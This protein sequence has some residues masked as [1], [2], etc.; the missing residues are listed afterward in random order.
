MQL[1]KHI[2]HTAKVPFKLVCVLLALS[3]FNS[4]LHGNAA[5]PSDD[6]I[7][8]WTLSHL[9][10]RLTEIDSELPQLSQLSLRGGVG[11]IGYR[12]AWWQAAVG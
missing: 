10:E 1:K 4:L 6:S 7:E 8:R 9:E 11:S 2:T 5:P 3:A 12:S